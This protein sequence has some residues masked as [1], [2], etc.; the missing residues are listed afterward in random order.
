MS[1]SPPEVSGFLVTWAIIFKLAEMACQ[2]AK[3]DSREAIASLLLSAIAFE[4]F[5]NE[6]VERAG[7]VAP[8]EHA[9]I[10]LFYSVLTDMEEE[11]AQ[12]KTKV[13]V[14]HFILTGA[15]L[16]RGASI[17]QNFDLLIRLR[18]SIAHH[19]PERMILTWLGEPP[20]APTPRVIKQLVF[21]G[22]CC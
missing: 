5:F 11:R 16:D 4:A 9:N 10:N 21:D 3:A 15:P 2:R 13:A 22:P 8:S 18:N 17:Y 12:L 19:R 14:G 1:T 7:K 6:L 20:D